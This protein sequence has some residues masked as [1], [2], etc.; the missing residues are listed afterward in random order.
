M[1]DD[2]KCYKGEE[3]SNFK[4]NIYI[5]KPILRGIQ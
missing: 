1:R 3:K 5:A 2:N 4:K